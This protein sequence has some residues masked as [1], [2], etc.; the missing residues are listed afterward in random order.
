MSPCIC[1]HTVKS[2]VADHLVL[3]FGLLIFLP[4]LTLSLEEIWD[5]LFK[6]D[7]YNRV[8]SHLVSSDENVLS[9]KGFQVLCGSDDQ[10]V[11]H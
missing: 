3:L 11:G 7:C 10:L 1:K 5:L 6:L 2:V 9:S 8:Y 4:Q